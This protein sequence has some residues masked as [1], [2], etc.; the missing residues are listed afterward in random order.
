MRL[1]LQ[2]PEGDNIRP[3]IVHNVHYTDHHTMNKQT[4][5]N[6]NKNTTAMS[7]TFNILCDTDYRTG[8]LPVSPGTPAA[9]SSVGRD[10]AF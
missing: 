4:K 1:I 7:V 3:K 8:C 5:N 2:S 9:S 10:A 6:N